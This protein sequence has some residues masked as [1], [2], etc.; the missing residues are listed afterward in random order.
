MS[1]DL[2]ID[3]SPELLGCIEPGYW[4]GVPV[5]DD[6]RQPNFYNEERREQAARYFGRY[7]QGELR[8]EPLRRQDIKGKLEP[9]RTLKRVSCLPATDFRKGTIVHTT[10]VVCVTDG[11]EVSQDDPLRLVSVTSS[12]FTVLTDTR[13]DK[14]HLKIWARIKDDGIE[15]AKTQGNRVGVNK[16]NL[17]T[18]IYFGRWAAF[19][20]RNGGVLWEHRIMG[21]VEGPVRKR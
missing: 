7:L 12:L 18:L 13:P 20:K 8:L 1:T 6:I 17:A 16:I 21:D 15:L 14:Q 9:H 2:H 5:L 4:D 19:G 10:K 11:P 3:M